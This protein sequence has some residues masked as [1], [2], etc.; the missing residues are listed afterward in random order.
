MLRYLVLGL[1]AGSI[2]NFQT[3]AQEPPS[4]AK[5]SD[6][7]PNF[8]FVT[9]VDKPAPTREAIA[10]ALKRYLPANEVVTKIEVDEK[11]ITFSLGEDSVIM[12]L[13]DVPIPWGDLE[14]PCATS[15]LWKDATE[16]MKAHRGHAIVFLQT[17]RGTQ[18]EQSILLTK[19][20]AAAAEFLKGTGVYWGEGS[21]VLPP[22]QWQKL[23]LD[24]TTDHPPLPAWIEFRAARSADAKIS[25]LT[26]GL[27]H[28]G[29]MEVEVIDS[30]HNFKDVLNVVMGVAHITIKG[31]KISDGDTVGG[32]ADTKIKVRHEKSVWDREG[33]VLRI[34]Y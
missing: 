12:A 7:K 18:L 34:D 17:G 26:T 27:E 1:V 32:D 3:R 2:V 20:I 28:F 14:G 33:K 21:V 24:A 19:V 8:A 30:R 10:A 29:G 22:D 5:E 16:V 11:A 15:W 9:F 23:A 25:V 13:T 31:E 4:D 6:K